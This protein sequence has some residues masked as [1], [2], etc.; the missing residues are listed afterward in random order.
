MITSHT[1]IH[2]DPTS[3]ILWLVGLVILS[4]VGRGRVKVDLNM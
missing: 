1:L 3:T 4:V 2:A